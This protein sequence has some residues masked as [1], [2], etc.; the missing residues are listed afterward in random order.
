MH[1][2]HI[3]TASL[4]SLHCKSAFDSFLYQVLLCVVGMPVKM[5][6]LMTMSNIERNVV[7]TEYDSA[8]CTILEPYAYIVIVL[9]T[10]ECIFDFRIMEK[11]VV[12][13]LDKNDLTVKVFDKVFRITV[14]CLSDHITEHIYQITFGNLIIPSADKFR[15]H[16]FHRCKWAVV[17][18]NHVRVTKMQVRCEE[19]LVWITLQFL[20]IRVFCLQK[21]FRKT[22]VVL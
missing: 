13:T 7:V 18:S 1:A 16:F 6:C 20:F 8:I 15:V 9:Y 21:R 5:Y 14:K 22:V 4:K 2:A 19:N 10:C 11:A 17:K 12:I 3:V